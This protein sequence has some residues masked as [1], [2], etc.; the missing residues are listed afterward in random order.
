VKKR[1]DLSKDTIPEALY[2][3]NY[4]RSPSLFSEVT[5]TAYWYL[6]ITK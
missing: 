3:K 2:P 1:K 4:A 6:T 5:F